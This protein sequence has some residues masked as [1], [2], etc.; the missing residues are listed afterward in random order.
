ML[1]LSIFHPAL[2]KHLGPTAGSS[3]LDNPSAS[4][5]ASAIRRRNWR[6]NNLPGVFLPT[7][8]TLGM[9]IVRGRTEKKNFS[10]ARTNGAQVRRGALAIR[11]AGGDGANKPPTPPLGPTRE[12]FLLEKKIKSGAFNLSWG[13]K[14]RNGRTFEGS[15]GGLAGE[16]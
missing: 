3:G 9:T 7:S 10:R 16:T 5:R 6:D 2:R 13:T 8:D 1:P 4:A 12:R 11:Q 15:S 14:G